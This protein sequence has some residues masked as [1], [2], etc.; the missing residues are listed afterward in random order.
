MFWLL[1]ATWYFHFMADLAK[2]IEHTLLR[3]DAT[4]ADI[5]KLCSEAIQRSF[6]GVCVNSCY[7]ALAKSLLKNH[8]PKLVSVVG[9]PLGTMESQAKAAE[10]SRAIDLG[11]DEIDM[12]LHVGALKEKRYDFVQRDIEIVLKACARRPLKVILETGILSHQ[13]KILACRLSQSAGAQFVKTCTGFAPGQAE[14]ADV[15]LMRA[16]VGKNMGVKAS[17]G[18]KTAEK[19]WALIRAGADRLGTSSGVQL[20]TGQAGGQ[21]Y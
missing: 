19:A 9:F 5:R 2:H 10:T 17:G 14:V 8:T 11:A 18:I 13:E 20:V 6:F 3:S 12:V 1:F 15:E 7:V 21:A 4:E 16:T